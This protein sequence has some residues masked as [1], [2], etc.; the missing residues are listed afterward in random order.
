MAQVFSTSESYRTAPHEEVIGR[1]IDSF[2]LV[3]QDNRWWILTIV[4]QPER[5]DLPPP[6]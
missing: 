5:P 6:Q 1:G 3:R 2:Q 4:W